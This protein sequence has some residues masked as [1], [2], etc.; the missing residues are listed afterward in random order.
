M[1]ER[2]PAV[3]T[4]TLLRLSLELT[5]FKNEIEPWLATELQSR[6]A[7]WLRTLEE[8]GLMFP[9]IMLQTMPVLYRL[10]VPLEAEQRTERLREQT[11]RM[12]MSIGQYQT[13]LNILQTTPAADP[14]WIAECHEKLGELDVA[15]A[16]YL[17]AGSVADALRCYRMVPDFDKTLSLLETVGK[18]P[19]RASLE[20]V[21][22]MRDLAAER[23]AEF[24][25]QILPSEKQLL[26]EVLQTA[27]GVTRKKP[28]A[29][30]KTAAKKVAAP[31]KK[32]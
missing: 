23:P 11:I 14:K 8:R 21:K 18:H 28:A 29:K 31:K 30:K 25:K 4:H 9:D 3:N 27:L 20:W 24:S 16:D 15:A 17:K 2:D 26:E 10:F 19:A 5:E 6:S 7:T 13:A 12:L 22:K 32:G 1:Q